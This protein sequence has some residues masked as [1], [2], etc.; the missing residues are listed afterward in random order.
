M[1]EPIGPISKA[2]FKAIARQYAKEKGIK[3]THAHELI[4]KFLGFRTYNSY[5]AS[6]KNVK[7][8]TRRPDA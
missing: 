5:L 8:I 2:Q 4:A 3:P 1:K 7:S 6:L